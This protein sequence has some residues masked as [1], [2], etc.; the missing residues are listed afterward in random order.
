MFVLDL[1]QGVLHGRFDVGFAPR[2]VFFEFD[3]ISLAVRAV[4]DVGAGRNG[5]TPQCRT[6]DKS[7]DGPQGKLIGADEPTKTRSAIE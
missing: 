1:F 7:L 4:W 3:H 6:L 5:R 2:I